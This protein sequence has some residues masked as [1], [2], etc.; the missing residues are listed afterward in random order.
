MSDRFAS[1]CF[2]SYNRP[3]FIGEAIMSASRLAGY[4]HEVL[5]HDD[6]SG[7][8]VIPML[9]T[10]LDAGY[11]S[12]LTLN[13][14]G[15]N[16]GVGEAIRRMFDMAQG[17]VL[18]KLDQD[19]LFTPDWLAKTVEILDADPTVGMFGFFK[20][21]H[22]PVDWRKMQIRVPT[23]SDDLVDLAPY[24][25]TRQFC[26]S[27]FAIPRRV[28][29]RLG[30]LDSHLDAFNE[31]S[32]FMTKVRAAFVDE[33]PGQSDDHGRF[34]LALPDTDL[35]TN[36]GFGI[37]PS[38]VVE[39]G[40]VVHK[41]HHGPYVIPASGVRQG[42]SGLQT[43]AT[44]P[45]DTGVDMEVG[46]GA[47]TPSN[48]SS[49]RNTLQLRAGRSVPAGASG[50]S[51]VERGEEAMECRGQGTNPSGRPSSDASP[52][53]FDVGIVITTCA[54][55]EENLKRALH[56]VAQLTWQPLGVVIVYDGCVTEPAPQS[57]AG[58][59]PIWR[60]AINKHG[61]GQ[62]Q[63]R[64]VGVRQIGVAF[65]ECNYVWFLDSDI[66]VPSDTLANFF[67]GLCAAPE[68]RVLIG[69][70]DW[71]G[72]GVLGFIPEMKGMSREE[73]A[74]RHLGM[75][76][77]RWEMF[78]A[79]GPERVF[80]RDLGCALGCFSGNLIWPIDMFKRV[81]G[82]NIELHHG[83]CEDGELGLRAMEHGIPM[84]LVREA[85]GWHIWHPIDTPSVLEKNARDVPLL[86][87]MHPWVE[88]EGLIVVPKDGTR[89]D[90]KC[91]ECGEV[92]NSLDY[93]PHAQ[94][95][96]TGV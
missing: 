13:R 28:F 57:F 53:K 20:Y 40:Y 92:V 41:I 44:A 7:P 26:G 37:G 74:A 64:N 69:P 42:E 33:Q 66:I 23:R 94:Q 60:V 22:E 56:H 16:E 72:P 35:A 39:E 58:A 61:P 80:V 36:R 32:N 87:A 82:F 71:N 86:N 38:T 11:I 30:P 51:A 10:L 9:L 45:Q 5:V 24:H 67:D 25:Y 12:H 15:H 18:I 88:N 91:P 3:A 8:D 90:F 93:W 50:P 21:N 29:D 89:F 17:D 79:N 19:M 77:Y 63:P 85:R 47:P 54:G 83:R 96:Q 70:Y 84:S 4:P 27:G 48:E 73:A 76:D 78:M 81:G 43:A 6:G 68:D 31:D 34:E 46:G 49:P 14:Q 1:L 59:T 62:E 55:R 95:H 65:P 75:P 2:L 52:R